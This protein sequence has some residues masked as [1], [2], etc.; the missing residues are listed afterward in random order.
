VSTSAVSAPTALR[1]P[2]EAARIPGFLHR[3]LRRPLAVVCIIYLLIVIATAVFAPILLPD[4]ANERVGDLLHTKEGPS[5]DHPLG[6]D[7]LGRDVLDRLLVGTRITMIGVAEALIVST[8]IAVPLGLAAGYFGGRFD[9]SVSWL[10]DL[11]FSIPALIIILVV[12]SI[13]PKSLLAAMITLGLLTAPGKARVIRAVTLPVREELY[14]AAARVSG[15]SQPYIIG[16]H[17][18]PRIAGVVIVQ[19]ALFAAAAVGVTAGLAFL[20][21]LDT[22]VPTWGGMVQDGISVLQLQPWLIWPP[23]IAIGLTV[24]A[25]TLLGDAVRDATAESWSA[26]PRRKRSR[27]IEAEPRASVDR[28]GVLLSVEKLTVAF[29]SPTASVPVVERVSFQVG[30]GE[31]VGIVGESGCGKTMTAMAILGLLPGVGEIESG[32]IISRG[33][34]LTALTER[35]LRNVR[36]KEIALISQEPMVSLTPTFRVGWQVAEAVRRHHHVSS[37][38]ARARTLELL[39]Q[40]RLP[41]PEVVAQRYPHELSGGMA[42]RVAIA[43]ALAGE[44]KLLI[45]DEPTTALDVTV[46]SEILDLLRML[47]EDRGLAILV[48]TH[49]WGVIA[50][51]CDRVVV[52][53]AG[54]VVEQGDLVRI[55]EEPLHPYT[56]ALLASNPHHAHDAAR[57]PTIPGSVPKPGHWPSG[58]HFHPRCRYATRECEGEPIPLERPAQGRQTRCIHHRLLAVPEKHE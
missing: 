33:R 1:E 31:A 37:R 58:C 49:D 55:F 40:V 11:A 18:L 22:S 3:L 57:L 24:L 46:Q 5:M 54:Q 34:D 16:R 25:F 23:G 41:D 2:G 4:T 12:V 47:R 26:P 7:T 9:R 30:E 29:P 19:A 45:A 44:P 51:I 17:V 36:G 15:L 52:M 20:G 6:T 35:E 53:Y 43:R 48:I 21:V 14:V 27:P 10:T 32:S 8:L 56:E 50:D 39:R 42:Q 38:A 13:F 28:S